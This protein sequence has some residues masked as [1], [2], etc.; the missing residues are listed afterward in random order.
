MM[1]LTS[2]RKPSQKTKILCKK[3]ALF[4]DA[5]YMTRGKM[6][7]SDVLEN[8]SGGILLVVGEFHG[9]PGSL[10]FYDESGKTFLSVYISE[11]YPEPV[12]QD[13]IHF[14]R[15]I[16]CGTESSA[17]FRLLN[18]FLLG[19][20]GE[21]VSGSSVSKLKSSPVKK[22]TLKTDG[23]VLTAKEKNAAFVR[24]LEIYDDRLDF[25]SNGR[26]FMRLYVKSVKAD[27]DGHENSGDRIN[28]NDSYSED[29]S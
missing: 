29:A 13:D 4:F 7:F 18:E 2:S 11:S 1:L 27:G 14:G 24:K 16:F 9:N 6:S 10:S 25:S 21:T 23:K 12:P 3:L 20:A 17:V 15:H 28:T 5:A 19:G 8:G 22:E 26:I